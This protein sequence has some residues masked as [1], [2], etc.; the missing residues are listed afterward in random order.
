MRGDARRGATLPALPRFA[1]LKASVR[2]ERWLSQQA[3]ELPQTLAFTLYLP[4]VAM[5]GA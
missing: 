3:S 2:V 4:R 5:W 1:Y